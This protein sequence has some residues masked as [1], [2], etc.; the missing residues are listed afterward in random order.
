MTV[1]FYIGPKFAT[2]ALFLHLLRPCKSFTVLTQF[3]PYIYKSLRPSTVVNHSPWSQ[4][5]LP[6]C[7]SFP[8]LLL[9]VNDLPSSCRGP[10]RHTQL[11]HS[12]ALVQ[13]FSFLVSYS[14]LLAL[15]YVNTCS[16]SSYSRLLAALSG[17]ELW[18]MYV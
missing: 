6:T 3:L 7:S 18:H 12:P 2:P 17:H 13:T 4:L 5:F 10:L 1:N 9:P 11:T 14:D 8:M 16:S 15:P